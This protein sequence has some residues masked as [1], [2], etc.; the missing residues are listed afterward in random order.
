VSAVLRAAGPEFDVDAFLAGCT[1][2]VCHVYRRGEPLD[3]A[4][5][6][7]RLNRLSG[8]SVEVSD[9]GFDE[10]AE[11]VAD[12]VAFLWAEAG[13]VRR[14]VGWPGVEGV[15]L[16]FGLAWRDVVAQTDHFP[17]E[18][19]RLTGEMGLALELSHYPVSAEAPDAE[20][21]AAPDPAGI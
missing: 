6:G 1:M 5:P 4:H 17:A 18:L 13:Q 14:L 20:P 16:D 7:G 2:P 11:Q 19:V 3:P 9:A 15:T 10:F 8:V 21:G 12:A